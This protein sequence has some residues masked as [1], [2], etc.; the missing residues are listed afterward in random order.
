MRFKS[1]KIRY[2]S[3]FSFLGSVCSRWYGPNM[4]MSPNPAQHYT[5]YIP[6]Y[7]PLGNIELKKV[8]GVGEKL[9]IRKVKGSVC[10]LNNFS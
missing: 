6:L 2:F 5:L 8:Y 3:S 4:M 1:L 10:W 9:K 7:Q